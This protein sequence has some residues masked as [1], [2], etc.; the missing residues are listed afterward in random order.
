TAVSLMDKRHAALEE[1]CQLAHLADTIEPTSHEHAANLGEIRF[2]QVLKDF[3]IDSPEM[4]R[5]EFEKI[6]QLQHELEFN[7]H[8]FQADARCLAA[9]QRDAKEA[10]ESLR[11]CQEESRTLK[12]KVRMLEEQLAQK[13]KLLRE[14]EDAAVQ[15]NTVQTIAERSPFGKPRQKLSGFQSKSF[16]G[17]REVPRRYYEETEAILNETERYGTYGVD[18]EFERSPVRLNSAVRNE[19]TE[20]FS[21]FLIT[22]SIP[23]PPVFSAA[24]GKLSIS[25][26]AKT[27]KMKFGT[28][29]QEFQITLLE[30][31]Y[32]EGKALKVFK[33]IPLD[34]K[35]TVEATLKAMASRLR[36][37]AED[38]S[39]KAKTKWEA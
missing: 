26:F 13:G 2:E 4:L 39:R 3:R 1:V 19:D 35:T 17:E 37:S 6:F 32:L 15:N 25:T 28:L 30:T 21:Q 38:E 7:K 24:P 31:K 14:A 5:E 12:Y 20:L 9:A 10:Q 8:Q 16:V 22:Q 36:V 23:E 34:E 11:L 18:Q 29:P 27:F 33:G